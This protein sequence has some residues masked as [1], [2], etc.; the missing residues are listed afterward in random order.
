MRNSRPGC[1]AGPRVTTGTP[2][3]GGPEGWD[4]DVASFYCEAEGDVLL[5]DPMVPADGSEREHFWLLD[6]AGEGRCAPRGFHLRG[7]RSAG[8][9]LNRYTGA[10]LWS[11]A[12]DLDELPAGVVATG[13]FRPG[14]QLPGGTS[15]IEGVV[16]GGGEVLLWIPTHGALAAG[17]SLGVGAARD[18]DVP[19]LL[20]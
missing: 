16:G 19:G 1:G 4:P 14:D 12:D 10:Q 2:D 11:H 8:D 9:I 13:P 5:I 6:D 17:D 15:A 3:Q 20:A 7:A 18:P